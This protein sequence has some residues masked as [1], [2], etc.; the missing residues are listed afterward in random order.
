M[1]MMF[2]ECF[3]VH[4]LFESLFGLIT[5]RIAQ[6]TDINILFTSD[7][8]R[9]TDLVSVSTQTLPTKDAVVYIPPNEIVEWEE[10]Q[11]WSDDGEV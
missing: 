10:W 7:G 8:K 9:T 3:N 2:G 6:I 5:G 11:Q 4:T 1:N